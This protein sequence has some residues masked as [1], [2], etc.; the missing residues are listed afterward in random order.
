[1][2][3]LQKNCINKKTASRKTPTSRSRTL[4]LSFPS[5]KHL[6]QNSAPSATKP[7]L[8]WV[9]K[10]LGH[11]GHD[12]PS[13]ASRAASHAQHLVSDCKAHQY[14]SRF[15]NRDHLRLPRTHQN[16]HQAARDLQERALVRV[17]HGQAVAISRLQ[18]EVPCSIQG[19][20]FQGRLR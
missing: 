4:M 17:H 18:D 5:S 9:W 15:A 16:V 10:T 2:Q 8:H 14:E 1:M 13:G 11:P 12:H 19:Q 7:P 6:S 3:T 20:P